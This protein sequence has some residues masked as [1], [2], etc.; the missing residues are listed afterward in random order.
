MA[1]DVT[2]SVGADTGKAR[3]DM[4]SLRKVVEEFFSSLGLGKAEAKAFAE[5]Y[6]IEF[7]KVGA[8]TEEAKARLEELRP[9]L[10][11]LAEE[12]RTAGSGT[13]EFSFNLKDMAKN[14]G[15]GI[16]VLGVLRENLQD[17]APILE[18]NGELLGD[19]AV[20][21]G[22]DE[23]TLNGLSLALDTLLHPTHAIANANKAAAEASRI[24]ADAY[25]GETEVVSN[26]T[27]EQRKLAA[28]KGD[29]LRAGQDREAAIK[30]E[31]EENAALA[32]VLSNVAA[33]ELKN[34]DVSKR[35]REE[36][37]K[38]NQAYADTGDQVPPKLAA[39][40][41]QLG[42]LTKEQ[43]KAGKEAE[44]L[45]DRA[46]KDAERRA[47]AEE[48]AAERIAKALE[49]NRDRIVEQVKVYEDAVK[50]LDAV[51]EKL[52]EAQR[53]DIFGKPV[54]AANE[55][56]DELTRKVADL[57]SQPIIDYAE[58]AKAEDALKDLKL[59]ARAPFPG[60]DTGPDP[61]AKLIEE[62]AKLQAAH[63]KEAEKLDKLYDQRAKLTGAEVE[64][65][66]TQAALGAE[67]ARTGVAADVTVQAFDNYLASMAETD[68]VTQEAAGSTATLGEEAAG[69]AVRIE[70]LADGTQ[71]ITNVADKMG[72][73]FSKVGDIL[74]EDFG[75]GELKIRNTGSA[76]EYLKDTAE[77]AS[78]SVEGLSQAV[79]EVGKGEG[80]GEPLASLQEGL[81]KS[82]TG[83]DELLEG[84]KALNEEL[85]ETLRLA[86]EIREVLGGLRLGAE[87]GA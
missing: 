76:A 84:A 6:A 43:E 5:A 21:A 42:I 7:T 2:L 53:T 57:R 47:K 31:R 13:G 41:A 60:Q 56:V 72:D 59:K 9:E 49:T 55:S 77:Q 38:L 75:E 39:V 61:N 11:K 16:S 46:E 48:K 24:V 63:D 28:A 52:A 27:A 50:R 35:T 26:L 82:K 14:V 67:V 78:G 62:Q 12:A 10:S 65:V 20:S 8:S 33:E 68:R 51:N 18:R 30:K 80:G 23:K 32:E 69:A 66:A 34:G 83:T 19:L 73:V 79:A 36:I 44:R 29:A 71:K 37:E 22:A 45:A 25:V 54:N 40:V 3:A 87:E 4:A 86:G 58:L 17:L 85:R 1:E 15:A 64:S 74:V 70:T 81:Q